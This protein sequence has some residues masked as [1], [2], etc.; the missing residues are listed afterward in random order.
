MPTHPPEAW[1]LACPPRLLCSHPVADTITGFTATPVSQRP[2][3][4]DADT[5]GIISAPPVDAGHLLFCGGCKNL[6]KVYVE[7]SKET[8]AATW[9]FVVVAVGM[10]GGS[11]WARVPFTARATAASG[12]AFKW[13]RWREVP[14]DA[15]KPPRRATLGGLLAVYAGHLSNLIQSIY[16]FFV[17]VCPVSELVG[18]SM[19]QQWQK[20]K[21][22]LSF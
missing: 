9:S 4:S 1:K 16:P 3:S 11:R 5:S 22:N 17:C 14:W 18:L 2:N 20:T 12:A 13:R 15:G 21:P 19:C 7:A 8:A 10:S 6:T